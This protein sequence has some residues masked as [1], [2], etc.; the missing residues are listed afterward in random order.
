[1]HLSYSKLGVLMLCFV[2]LETAKTS[3]TLKSMPYCQGQNVCCVAI[4][5]YTGKCCFIVYWLL[6]KIPMSENHTV[7]HETY[8]SES[9]EL[10]QTNRE[11]GSRYSGL[12]LE[13][14]NSTYVLLLCGENWVL[15][16]PNS[17]DLRKRKEHIKNSRQREQTEIQAVPL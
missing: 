10:E 14:L 9:T 13:G 17:E 4:Y 3:Q 2:G 8:L 11:G 5:L 12:Y 6:N 7:N 16:M 1:M 15:L